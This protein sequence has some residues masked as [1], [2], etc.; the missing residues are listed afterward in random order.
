[1]A[2]PKQGL[3]SSSGAFIFRGGG[4]GKGRLVEDAGSREEQN[5]EAP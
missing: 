3:L 4:S 1:M 2:R 5:R